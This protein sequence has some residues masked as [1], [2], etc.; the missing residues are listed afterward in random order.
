MKSRLSEEEHIYK[1][2]L[3]DAASTAFSTLHRDHSSALWGVKPNYE[4][5]IFLPR[6]RPYKPSLNAVLSPFIFTRINKCLQTALVPA[7]LKMT[8]SHFNILGKSNLHLSSY[9]GFL[10]SSPPCVILIKQVTCCCCCCCG[11]EEELFW[12]GFIVCLTWSSLV[13]S[14]FVAIQ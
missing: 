12:D 10:T 6:L 8:S 5:T 4:S 14:S 11:C 2:G 7:A 3:F 13:Q 9:S 1:V